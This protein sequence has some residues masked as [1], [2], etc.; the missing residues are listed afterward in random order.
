MKNILFADFTPIDSIEFFT[1]DHKPRYLTEV[2]EDGKPVIYKVRTILEDPEDAHQSVAL[3][4]HNVTMNTPV[5]TPYGFYV[6]G[7]GIVP[8]K[9]LIVEP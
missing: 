1:Q 9:H 5:P 8:A 7:F 3:Y 4:N 6:R 2:R